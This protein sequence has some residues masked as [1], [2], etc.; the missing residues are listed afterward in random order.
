M[1][2]KLKATT[3][4]S[5]LLLLL[6]ASFKSVQGSDYLQGKALRLITMQRLKIQKFQFLLGFPAISSRCS[7]EEAP[8]A[9]CS[10]GLSVWHLD[11]LGNS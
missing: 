3:S 8:Q 9:S 6:G 10:V 5:L 11:P 7:Q 2:S 4:T 1:S